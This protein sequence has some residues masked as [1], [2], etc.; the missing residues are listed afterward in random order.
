MVGPTGAGKTTLAQAILPR[1]DYAV[2]LASKP[3]DPVV[4]SL[5]RLDSWQVTR[6][7]PAYG[8]RLV[9]WPRIERTEDLPRQREVFQ[10]CLTDA[11]RSGG[12][13][14]YADEL[15]YICDYL[16]L[17]NLMEL[18]WLQ[19]RSLGLSVVAGAQRPRHVPLAAYSMAT[20]LFLWR[21]RDAADLRR[22]SEIGG[23]DTKAVSA[24][25]ARLRGHQV[26]YV[27]SDGVMLSTEVEAN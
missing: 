2:V 20:H 23:V 24:E 10:A 14:I 9:L 19:G 26:L 27:S 1:R 25:V 3:K 18:L 7:W 16:R 4:A 15:Q 22:L 11:Y 6:T 17:G 13:T 8:Q 21:T 12:W 5:R